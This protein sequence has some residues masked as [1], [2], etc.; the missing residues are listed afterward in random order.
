MKPPLLIAQ[1]SQLHSSSEESVW[2][3]CPTECSRILEDSALFVRAS[4]LTPC[5]WRAL[6]RIW[7]SAQAGCQALVFIL[8]AQR[9]LPK[10]SRL[11]LWHNFHNAAIKK[12]NCRRF[13]CPSYF[14]I[15]DKLSSL[16]LGYHSHVYQ[17]PH[18]QV[19]SLLSPRRA[20]S[21]NPWPWELFGSTLLGEC[22]PGAGVLYSYPKLFFS[23]SWTDNP[24]NVSLHVI[25]ECQ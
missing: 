21:N 13:W 8:W 14:Q 25:N 3:L 11:N 20:A 1:I 19:H 15:C 12:E 22:A 23:S 10:K 16:L 4:V 6:G 9:K 7:S 17:Y 24:V 18:Q 2:S 5:T